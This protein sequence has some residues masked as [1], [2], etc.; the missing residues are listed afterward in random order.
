[1]VFKLTVSI[2]LCE[3][4]SRVPI[5]VPIESRKRQI[6]VCDVVADSLLWLKVLPYF[7]D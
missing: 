4:A 7:E 6:N 3:N 1:M 2:V 5:K